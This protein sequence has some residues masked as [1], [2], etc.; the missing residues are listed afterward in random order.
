M[1]V[2]F[3]TATRHKEDCAVCKGTGQIIENATDGV[4]CISFKRPPQVLFWQHLKSGN[5]CATLEIRV[6]LVANSKDQLMELRENPLA[7]PQY[8][9]WV[10][11]VRM[12]TKP[13][14]RKEGIMTELVQ[15]AVSGPRIM[16]AETSWEDSTDEGRSLLLKLGFAQEGDKLIWRDPQ[17]VNFLNGGNRSANTGTGSGD[18]G[19]Q[20]GLPIEQY[21]DGLGDA[22]DLADGSVPESPGQGSSCSGITPPAQTEESG[23]SGGDEQTSN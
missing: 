5:V 18:S 6:H 20:D 13:K 17:Y 7:P 10:E 16:W 2:D 8:A 23:T 12:N 4:T 3:L 14:H 11:L 19:E 22:A 1:K 15:R 9:L 21:D